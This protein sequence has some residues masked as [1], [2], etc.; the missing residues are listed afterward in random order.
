MSHLV[1]ES[2]CGGA[3]EPWLVKRFVSILEANPAK[4]A[5]NDVVRAGTPPGLLQMTAGTP[6]LPDIDGNAEQ[7]QHESVEHRFGAAT[8]QREHREHECDHLDRR[9]R[10]ARARRR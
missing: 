3:D 8:V 2:F 1:W 7:Q 9:S 6:P 10:A 4:D 5:S